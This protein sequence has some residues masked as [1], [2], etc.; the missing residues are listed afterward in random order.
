[1]A[2]PTITM[3][4]HDG[5]NTAVTVSLGGLADLTA[6]QVNTHKRT[7]I[8]ANGT[9]VEATVNLPGYTPANGAE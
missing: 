2:K 7:F 4:K 5:S 1:M 6:T 8:L 9:T 3:Y